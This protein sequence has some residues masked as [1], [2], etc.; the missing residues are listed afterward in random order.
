MDNI[1][2]ENFLPTK[3]FQTTVCIVA[4]AI[5]LYI[6]IGEVLY[7]GR[8][9]T[10]A[11]L[12]E[13]QCNTKL[14]TPGI[15]I[16]S[17][18]VITYINYTSRSDMGKPELVTSDN[19]EFLTTRVPDIL[20]WE[21]ITVLTSQQFLHNAVT[22]INQKSDM[23][24]YAFF[25]AKVDYLNRQEYKVIGH[26][27][28][29]LRF[30][31]RCP[32]LGLGTAETWFLRYESASYLDT[33]RALVMYN[34]IIFEV[35]EFSVL[36]CYSVPKLCHYTFP[37]LKWEMVSDGDFPS[38]AFAA[39]VAP[40]GET[41]CIGRAQY[42]DNYIIPGYVVPSER[43]FHLS[44][45]DREYCHDNTFKI[46]KSVN[47]DVLEWGRYSRGEIPP[48]AAE[49]GCYKN[50]KIFIGRTVADGDISLGRTRHL[51]KISLPED[52]V[53]NAQLVGKI[54][55]TYQCLYV[56]WDGKEYFYQLYEVLMVKMRPKSLQHLCRNVIV[57]AILGIP[58][59]V[60]KLSLPKHLKKF[61][62]ADINESQHLLKSI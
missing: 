51:D 13:S 16:P 2:H 11:G 50:E 25:I 20:H 55:N 31:F 62:K 24:H 41:L 18:N 35:S 30:D 42:G 5:N 57:T 19:Y 56:P 49:V 23:N 9:T 8:A 34:G 60:D 14:T 48:N 59:R 15:I 36:C 7:I 1:T 45:E 44:W 39:G 37:E 52:T 21:S 17:Q 27:D 26:C 28:A 38:N 3:Y 32:L 29:K 61:C 10:N 33:L 43:R 6:S 54:M 58:G 46:L 22:T 4:T 47:E 40:S 53:S 12:E